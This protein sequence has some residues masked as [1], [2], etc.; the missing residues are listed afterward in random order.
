MKPLRCLDATAGRIPLL[1]LHTFLQPTT[2]TPMETV[3]TTMVL[4]TVV[5]IVSALAAA[6]PL[7]NRKNSVHTQSASVR[8]RRHQGRRQ[9]RRRTRRRLCSQPLFKKLM[10]AMQSVII[11]LRIIRF[12]TQTCA[13]NMRHWLVTHRMLAWQFNTKGRVLL[14][15]AMREVDT[16]FST[17]TVSQRAAQRH[18]PGAI[19]TGAKV[20]SALQVWRIR[21]HQIRL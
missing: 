2:S 4:R 16:P 9:R 11:R 21:L 6:I 17:A 13:C 18:L 8:Q 1:T 7:L 19:Q 3:A 5:K 10:V 15:A 14:S 12:W 20:V